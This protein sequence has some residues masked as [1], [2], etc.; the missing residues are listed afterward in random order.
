MLHLLIQKIF[1]FLKIFNILKP[2]QIWRI[3]N[4]IGTN[5][6]GTRRQVSSAE[7]TLNWQ[8]ENAMAQNQAL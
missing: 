8:V 2:T 4:P 7:A 5:L 1:L 6:D 3:K